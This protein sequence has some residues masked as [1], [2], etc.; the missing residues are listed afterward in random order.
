MTK[1]VG[2]HRRRSV[3]TSGSVECPADAGKGKAAGNQLR[4]CGRVSFRPR[5]PKYSL[6][7]KNTPPTQY[8][9]KPSEVW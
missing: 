9:T 3:T 2:D 6:R 7:Q 1:A 8:T 5:T 4:A